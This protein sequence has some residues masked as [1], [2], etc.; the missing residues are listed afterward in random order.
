MDGHM[1]V[2]CGGGE[3]WHDSCLANEIW[4]DEFCQEK[5]L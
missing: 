4:M 1:S 2:R 5:G 3:P